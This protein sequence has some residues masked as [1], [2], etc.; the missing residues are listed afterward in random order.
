MILND[1][2]AGMTG[3]VSNV[4]MDHRFPKTVFLM[5]A[6]GDRPGVEQI[7]NTEHDLVAPVG[8]QVPLP[9]W[10]PPLALRD[11]AELD[12]VAVRF[13]DR[14]STSGKFVWDRTSYYEVIRS[15]WQ[16]RFPLTPDEVGSVLCAHGL[17]LE[18]VAEAHRAFLEGTGLLVYTHGRK[19]IKKKRVKRLLGL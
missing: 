1:F 5:V 4:D 9:G 19:P 13:C 11:A 8:S 10:L 6:D 2:R 16:R 17:S 7:V 3:T 15:C 14:C 12:E 18:F